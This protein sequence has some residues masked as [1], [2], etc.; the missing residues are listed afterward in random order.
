MFN[1][2]DEGSLALPICKLL[3]SSNMK[4]KLILRLKVLGI[5]AIAPD[6]YVFLSR[7]TSSFVR[8]IQPQI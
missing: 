1:E 2:N 4:L 5:L 3:V 6:G 7:L 8:Y